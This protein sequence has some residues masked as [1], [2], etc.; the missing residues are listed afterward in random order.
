M[1]K[2]GILVIM[3]MSLSTTVYSQ[4]LTPKKE[5]SMLL[6]SEKNSISVFQN[7]ADGVV[8][9]SNLRKSKSVFDM[10]ATEVATGM[11][12]GIVWDTAGH[13]ITNYH[14][15]DGGDAFTV[16]FRED[17]KI[18]RAKLVGGDPKNDIAVLQLEEVPKNL[19]PI[20]R[21]DSKI[22]LV[23]QKAL[24]IGNPLGLDHTLTTGSVSALD[25]KI[26]G[27]GGVTIN[28]MIQ[29]DASINPGNS[30]GALLDSSGKL[31]GMNAMI[32]NGGGSGSSAGL[33]FAIPVNIIK[34]VV[35]Q[36]I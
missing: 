9:V 19:K 35:P 33:G 4:Q 24:A 6:E 27:Y 12:S 20:A 29:T 10:D 36:L 23:G 16:A 32:Y 17:K 15:V 5:V 2:L 25:R 3:A 22:L 11:G 1:R 18:Y 34:D 8:N 31:I 14:V 30:G 13:I 28:G 21:G 7:T 26:P